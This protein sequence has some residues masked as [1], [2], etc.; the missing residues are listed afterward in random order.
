VQATT[1]SLPLLLLLLLLLV[2]GST[3]AAPSGNDSSVWKLSK[4]RQHVQ[5]TTAVQLGCCCFG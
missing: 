2:S 1:A 3:A 4:E 5:A